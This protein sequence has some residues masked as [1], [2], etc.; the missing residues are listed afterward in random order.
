MNGP[1]SGLH[2]VNFP[3][4]TN[5]AVDVTKFLILTKSFKILNLW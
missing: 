3:I 1:E 4:I 2:I 5:L